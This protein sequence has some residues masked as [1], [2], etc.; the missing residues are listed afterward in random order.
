MMT[1]FRVNRDPA[2]YDSIGRYE[3][4]KSMCDRIGWCIDRNDG[5]FRLSSPNSSM[6]MLITPSLDEVHGFIM[7]FMA[8]CRLEPGSPMILGED[9]V[10]LI[11][12]E[13][14]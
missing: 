3:A 5:M 4:I 13:E 14:T 6:Y 10:A 2:D 11:G 9:V 1:S 7:G 12:S 8:A